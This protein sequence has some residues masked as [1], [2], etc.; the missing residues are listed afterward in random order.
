MAETVQTPQEQP[1]AELTGQAEEIFRTMW[2]SLFYSGRQVGKSL[3]VCSANRSEGASTVVCGLG[4]AG[5]GPTGAARVAMVD[6]NLREPALHRMVGAKAAPGVAEIIADGL[7]PESAAQRINVG[8]DIYAAGNVDGRTL[9]VLRNGRLGEF[10]ATLS[11]GYDHVLV[12]AAAVNR[13]PDAQVLAS[14]V[15]DIVLVA[16]SQRTA[17]EAVAQARRSLEAGGGRIAGVVLNMRTYPIPK[18]L[19]RRL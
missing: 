2:A 14:V 12:D 17:R 7:A 16:H 9:D 13:F 19:Y 10:I 18:F 3:L 15:G 8:L 11:D 4:I 5:S 1:R 6:F